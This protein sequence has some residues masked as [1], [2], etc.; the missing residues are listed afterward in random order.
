MLVSKTLSQNKGQGWFYH[1]NIKFQ[2]TF[3]TFWGKKYFLT[4][5]G[6][7]A[8]VGPSPGPPW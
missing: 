1:I 5:L 6:F 8:G 7:H 3:F 4:F 2:I